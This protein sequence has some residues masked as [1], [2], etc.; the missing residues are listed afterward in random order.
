MDL[1]DVPPAA[2]QHDMVFQS[3]PTPGPAVVYVD[4]S[5]AETFAEGTEGLGLDTAGVDHDGDRRTRVRSRSSPI[6][7]PMWLAHRFG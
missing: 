7:R 1:S 3:P 6:R 4:S 5:H 2:Q